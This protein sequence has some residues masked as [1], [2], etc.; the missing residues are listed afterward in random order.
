MRDKR[1][2]ASHLRR[3]AANPRRYVAEGITHGT[4]AGYTDSQCRCNL[5]AAAKSEHDRR[6]G[7]RADAYSNSN[8]LV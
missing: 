3:Q 2:K 6:R 7:G 1:R 5:C 4:Y 8:T